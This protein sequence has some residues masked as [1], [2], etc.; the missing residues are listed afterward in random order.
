MENMDIVQKAENVIN[1][2]QRPNKRGDLVIDLTTNQIRK[3][4]AAVTITANKVSI[5]RS[6]HPQNKQLSD[7]LADEIRYLQVKLVYQA[8]R[9]KGVVKKFIKE[10]KLLT[11]IKDIG[12]SIVKFEKFYR[13][14]EALVAYHKYYG[15]KDA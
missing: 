15:G 5:Y 9:D 1:L 4:L 14:V 8:S 3:F 13:Y 10:A 12:N 11:L 2:L 7:E 6:K